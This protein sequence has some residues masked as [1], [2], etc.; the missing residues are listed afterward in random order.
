MPEPIVIATPFEFSARTTAAMQ[1]AA[2]EISICRVPALALRRALSQEELADARAAVANA[3][4]VLTTGWP[5]SE[6]LDAATNVKWLHAVGAG[7]DRLARDGT[8]QRGFLVSNSRGLASAA[9]AEWVIGTMVVLAKGIHHSLRA[10]TEHRWS[11]FRTGVLSGKTVGIIGLG[12]IGV[13]V[14]RRAAAFGMHVVASR[15]GAQPGDVAP[16]C[17]LLLPV[18]QVDR[19]IGQSDYVVLTVPLTDETRGMFGAAQLARM[20]PSACLVNVARGAVVDQ[21][22]LIDALRENRIAG[23]AL[24]VV[25]PEPLPPESPLWDLPNVIVT[26]HNSGAFEGYR[27]QSELHFLQNFLR[28]IAG[29]PL[30][31]LVDPLL[32]Y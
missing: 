30:E 31:S 17:E 16:D 27:D 12:A 7:V 14:A 15:R 18:N 13:E 1:D 8:L 4:I 26:P 29:E 9:I 20:K 5:I 22:A 23:A 11:F 25:D 10:Q 6:I 24:D 3:H 19:L 2:P 32:G 28:F 21:G